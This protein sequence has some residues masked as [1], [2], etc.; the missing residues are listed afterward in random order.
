MAYRRSYSRRRRGSFRVRRRG[1]F[2]RRIGF[3]M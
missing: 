1:G 2:A 3:R